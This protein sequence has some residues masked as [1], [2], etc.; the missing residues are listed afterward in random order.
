VTRRRTRR[1][2]GEAGAV[3][4][5]EV[6]PL[7]AL[8]LGVGAL[9]V[10][11][12]WAVVDA[13]LVA[14]SAARQAVRTFVEAPGHGVGPG[15]RAWALAEQAA[16]EVVAAEGRSP[17]RFRIEPVLLPSGLERCGRVVARASYRVPALALPGGRGRGAGITVTAV[18]TEAVDPYR[19]GLPTGGCGA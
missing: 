16:A 9:I 11:Q 18:A 4:G 6:L 5:A 2:R 13:R 17:E 14:H 10:A 7:G 1:C 8:V 19:A 12:A 15:A 3:A